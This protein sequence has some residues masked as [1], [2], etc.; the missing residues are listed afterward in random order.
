MRCFLLCLLLAAKLG[1]QDTLTLSEVVVKAAMLSPDRT[2]LPL[3]TRI[4]D[5]SSN[6][7]NPLSSVG[8]PGLQVSNLDNAAQDQRIAI[9]GF[10]ARAAFGI[11]GVNIYL[12]GIPMTTPDGQTQ[13]DH[14]PTHLLKR[15]S[16]LRGL[17][18]TRYGNASGGVIHLHT[19]DDIGSSG[20]IS[21]NY[22]SYQ[23]WSL[24]ATAQHERQKN[25]LIASVSTAS[26]KGFRNHSSFNNRQ[27]F[28]KYKRL[29]SDKLET[30]WSM[31]FMDSPYAYDAGALTLEE[32]QQS[33][34]QA[35]QRN[36]DFNAKESVKQIQVGINTKYKFQ[37]GTLNTNLHWSPRDYTGW[38]PFENNG[39]VDLNRTFYGANIEYQ[40]AM[41]KGKW[42]IGIDLQ[43]Q[44]DHRQR[45]QNLSGV[46]GTQGMDQ[47][48]SFGAQ[49]GYGLMVF[50]WGKLSTE[51]GLRF[52]Q[53]K[54]ELEDRFLEDGDQQAKKDYTVWTPTLGASWSLDEH[55]TLFANLGTG[56]ETPAL[57]ELSA[58]PYGAGF[59][60]E[61]EPSRSIGIDVGF[62][63]KTKR[64]QWEGVIF[65]SNTQNELVRYELETF[66]GQNFYRN[67]GTSTRYGLEMEGVLSIDKNQKIRASMTRAAYRFDHDGRELRIPGVAENTAHL[68]WQFNSK[69]WQLGLQ[70]NYQG[71]LNTDND[72]RT[73]VPSYILTN[74][75]IGYRLLL[76][77]ANTRLGIH[78]QNLTNTRYFDNIRINAFG[79]RYYE[80][81]AGRNFAL[82]L[83][84][85]F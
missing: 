24:A 25:K 45:F 13:I 22:G 69:H 14:I 50:K 53:Q 74:L 12:D 65:F 37:K 31:I 64:F 35:R 46:R 40:S 75:N 73:K 59:N 43:Q 81:A 55:N 78:I 83:E 21:A 47:I 60:P 76:L 34:A 33:R 72:N 32:V 52:D 42:L 39:M 10:G 57:S 11:R 61:I 18:G 84:C 48:E 56:Y 19:A 77:G 2:P 8:V 27:G 79:N 41:G 4:I 49:S 44:H 82:K 16:V 20:K 58:N 36:V 7:N 63:Q 68:G 85:F 3:S 62:R 70:T 9:R 38:L 17:S 28:L 15:V 54:L 26:K 1:A 5:E 29:W 67:L 80:P 30:T 51:I 66:P 6:D 23:W 71:A